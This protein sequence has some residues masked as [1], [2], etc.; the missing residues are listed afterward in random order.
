MAAKGQTI[1]RLLGIVYF[2]GALAISFV[3]V[4]LDGK[5]PESILVYLAIWVAGWIVPPIVA[6][7]IN[8]LRF[9]LWRRRGWTEVWVRSP[10]PLPGGLPDKWARGLI[11]VRAPLVDFLTDESW[12]GP[13][14]KP[15]SFL[16]R[17]P[18]ARD[19]KRLKVWDFMALNF[20]PGIRVVSLQTTRGAIDVAGYPEA[21]AEL[22]SELF[23]CL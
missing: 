7:V 12:E 21:L 16:V 3:L 2:V 17:G 11:S 22:E 23:G 10:E 4:V 9:K 8:R 18:I 1:R 15:A 13:W 5:W 6:R 20:G 14:V 19:R